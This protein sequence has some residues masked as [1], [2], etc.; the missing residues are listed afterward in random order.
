M[1]ERSEKCAIGICY[2]ARKK[3]V[4]PRVKMGSFKC[5]L[6]FS[7][8]TMHNKPTSQYFFHFLNTFFG[9]PQWR[10]AAVFAAWVIWRGGSINKIISVVNSRPDCRER[11]CFIGAKRKERERDC[12]SCLNL[13]RKYLFSLNIHILSV[14]GYEWKDLVIWTGNK[15]WSEWT[16][17]DRYSRRTFPSTSLCFQWD[18]EGLGIKQHSVEVLVSTARWL[19]WAGRSV[20]E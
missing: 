12:V 15:R 3:K 11:W 2:E 17:H 7:G 6:S 19:W 13:C 16:Q 1:P 8:K 9:Q 10:N 14:T 20:A 5:H 4:L 18:T